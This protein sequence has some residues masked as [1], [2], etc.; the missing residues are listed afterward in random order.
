M[1]HATESVNSFNAG[2]VENSKTIVIPRSTKNLEDGAPKF[3][4]NRNNFSRLSQGSIVAPRSIKNGVVNSGI[5]TSRSKKQLSK[6]R[7]L[8][9][10][11]DLEISKEKSSES[12]DAANKEGGGVND[13][14]KNGTSGI[15]GFFDN[16]WNAIF[17]RDSGQKDEEERKEGEIDGE[18][19]DV[20][21]DVLITGEFKRRASRDSLVQFKGEAKRNRLDLNLSRE[22]AAKASKR[23][24]ESHPG[25]K[26]SMASHY[27]VT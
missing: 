13:Q 10:I 8:L 17:A 26:S 22:N 11:R 25:V 1:V 3:D 2:R 5:D 27:G 23:H 21:N 15:A 16:A 18:Q 20:V 12:R 19:E 6:S 7:S 14:K 9:Q 24:A 4:F